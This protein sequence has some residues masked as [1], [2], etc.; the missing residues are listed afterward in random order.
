[1]RQSGPRVSKTLIFKVTLAFFF[2]IS[3]PIP[4]L[5]RETAKQKAISFKI[6]GDSKITCR[7]SLLFIIMDKQLTASNLRSSSK[8]EFEYVLNFLEKEE[9]EGGIFEAECRSVVDDGVFNEYAD[10]KDDDAADVTEFFT[11]K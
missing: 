8:H 4:F 7:P 10:K 9:T 3:L 5:S 6:P 1:M 11:E 2:L